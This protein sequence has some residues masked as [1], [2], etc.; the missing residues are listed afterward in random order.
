MYICIYVYRT[1]A[2]GNCLYNACSLALAGDESLAACL[3]CLISIELSRNPDY[4]ASHPIL[5]ELTKNNA[6]QNPD[7][8]FYLILSLK[9]TDSSQG[10]GTSAI[11]N[12]AF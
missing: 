12:E 5:H 2:D 8:I 9:S 7:N 3:R 11:Y 1:S 4:Y 10:N 6:F